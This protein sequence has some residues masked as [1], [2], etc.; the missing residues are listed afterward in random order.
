MKLTYNGDA[1]EVHLRGASHLNTKHGKVY[2]I[3]TLLYDKDR[4][5]MVRSEGSHDSEKSQSK[6]DVLGAKSHPRYIHT[7]KPLTVRIG[8]TNSVVWGMVCVV[9]FFLHKIHKPGLYGLDITP[10]KVENTSEEK[11]ASNR[12][13]ARD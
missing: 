10:V 1:L 7:Q 12:N 4:C 13:I 5:N 3:S 6:S 11:N 8:R 9:V 2:A